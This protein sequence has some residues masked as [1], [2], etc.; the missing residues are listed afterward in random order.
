MYVR[1]DARARETGARLVHACGF[2]SVPHDLG[3]YFTVRQ[4]PEGVPLQV[5][6]FVRVGRDLLRRHLRVRAQPRSGAAGRRWRAARDRRLARAPPGGP[7]G[8]AHRL[9]A[10]RFSRGDRR[11]GAA[12]ADDRRADRGRGR[13]GRW[14]GTARTSATAHYA[15]VKAPADGTRAAS[16]A[17]GALVAAAQLPPARR[18]LMR[19]VQAGRGARARSGARG[20]G[21]R[22]ASSARAAGAGSSP[23]S[24]AATRGTTRRR[25]CSPSRRSA[26]PSTTC[27]RRPGRS[28]R[29]SRWATRCSSGCGRPGSASGWRREPVR[30]GPHS[31]HWATV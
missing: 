31:A 5:D 24:R 16:A 23:R 20:A 21:S 11:L 29:R 12:A 27:R 15:A 17:V 10:P 30:A 18:W 2:D 25:R 7:A 3:A 6:G 13:R 4:L 22:C 28:R 9:G 19:P 1:H 26:W 8:H 14:S